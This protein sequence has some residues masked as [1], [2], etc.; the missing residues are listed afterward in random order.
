MHPDEPVPVKETKPKKVK[1]VKVT[2]EGTAQPKS[3][4]HLHKYDEIVT[5]TE[6]ATLFRIGTDCYWLPKSTY[7]MN[8]EKPN[9]VKAREWMEVTLKPYKEL[10]K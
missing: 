4:D 1:K 6:K 10:K 3:S 9:Q 7:W 5:H 2:G 8:P